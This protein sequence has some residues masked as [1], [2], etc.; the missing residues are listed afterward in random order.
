MEEYMK[1][2]SSISSTLALLLLSLGVAP[3]ANAVGLLGVGRP[4]TV[5]TNSAGAVVTVPGL[6][7]WFQD[8]NGVAVR[9]CL[10]TACGL[11]ARATVGVVGTPGFDPGFDLNLALTFPANFPDEA[12]YFAADAEFPVG[13]N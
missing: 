13:P 2:I 8:Q 6:P 5:F 7:A 10:D 4:P 1:L 11:V 9:P 12:F 3:S